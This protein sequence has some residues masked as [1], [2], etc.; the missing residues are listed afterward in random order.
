MHGKCTN[1]NCP[2]E[3]DVLKSAHN[4]RIINARGLTF[5]S[6]GILLELARV[7]ADPSRSV[8]EINTNNPIGIFFI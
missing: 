4:K 8:R 5:L 3:H 2:Y 1:P 6:D 7:S